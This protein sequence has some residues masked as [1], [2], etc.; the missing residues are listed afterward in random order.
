M[1]LN[2]KPVAH[3]LTT[4]IPIFIALISVVGSAESAEP[5]LTDDSFSVATFNIGRCFASCRIENDGRLSHPASKAVFDEIL[6]LKSQGADVILLQEVNGSNAYFEALGE[7]LWGSGSQNYQRMYGGYHGKAIYSR[8]PIKTFE[9]KA[10]RDSRTILRTVIQHPFDSNASLVIGNTHL[11]F[12]SYTSLPVADGS[13][14]W[15][16]TAYQWDQDLDFFE[17]IHAKHEELTIAGAP[18][19]VKNNFQGTE[20][21]LKKFTEWLLEKEGNC[22]FEDACNAQTLLVGDFNYRSHMDRYDNRHAYT[23]GSAWV[24]PSPWAGTK[25]LAENGWIDTYRA[26]N[27]DDS[28]APGITAPG[29]NQDRVDYIQ[30]RPSSEASEAPRM[31]PI[32]SWVLPNIWRDPYTLANYKNEAQA[33]DHQSVMTVFVP[34]SEHYRFYDGAYALQHNNVSAKKHGIKQYVNGAGFFQPFNYAGRSGSIDLGSSKSWR[35]D[36]GTLSVW[37]RLARE[38]C[39]SLSA[40]AGNTQSGGWALYCGKVNGRKILRGYAYSS[41]SNRYETIDSDINNWKGGSWHHVTLRYGEGELSLHIDG[42]KVKH[43]SIAISPMLYRAQNHF[44]LFA[45]ASGGAST[46][47]Y[48]FKGDIADV[49]VSPYALSDA[50]IAKMAHRGALTEVF[51]LTD[52]LNSTVS[53]N[54][55]LGN[56]T[57]SQDGADFDGHQSLYLNSKAVR[58]PALTVIGEFRF[59]NCSQ[60][61]F[62]FSSMYGDG[63]GIKYRGGKLIADLKSVS[64]INGRSDWFSTT[65]DWVCDTEWHDIAYSFNG[66]HLLL[67]VDGVATSTDLGLMTK[68]P[69]TG[70][71]T[72]GTNIYRMSEF[73]GIHY[74]T[75]NLGLKVGDLSSAA[76]GGS[77]GLKFNGSIRN[78]K[79]LPVGLAKWQLSA[80]AETRA[81][82]R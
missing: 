11:R 71:A 15:P 45:E 6:R 36:Y 7:Q 5:T 18:Y 32:A 56:T 68:R 21:Q 48:H 30:Y 10:D 51:P 60:E 66:R 25:Y 26:A 64:A 69:A 35:P 20:L 67:S 76:P 29:W 81:G 39:N 80:I 38:N 44:Q 28:Q 46:A 47:G 50:T 62:L 49:L 1:F 61:A 43:K 57:I 27:P 17:T 37:T 82:L 22:S 40:I 72:G 75:N 42:V 41:A 13:E 23:P 8:L 34:V 53:N 70:W 54:S 31:S 59:D 12:T 24:K 52:N 33:A 16:Y 3:R 14:F 55:L 77:R 73:E 9:G 2:T 74:R 58:S 63:Y 4:L 78:L 65:H 79:I 19:Q